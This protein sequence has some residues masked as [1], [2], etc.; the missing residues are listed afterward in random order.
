VHI[1]GP[2]ATE[3]IALAS[4]AMKNELSLNEIREVVYPHPSFSESFLEAIN[5][6]LHMMNQ[7]TSP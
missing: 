4:M 1:I 6:A 5:D 3:L 7:N 2:Q